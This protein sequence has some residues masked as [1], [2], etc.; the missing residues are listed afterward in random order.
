MRQV[1][2]PAIVKDSGLRNRFCSLF[3][4]HSLGSKRQSGELRVWIQ[5][6]AG[7]QGGLEGVS[8]WNG[9]VL[10]IFLAA[11]HSL[12]RHISPSIHLIHLHSQ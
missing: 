11:K 10:L 4:P 2:R 9:R 1:V 7:G 12:W 8:A 5:T 3:E 6:N